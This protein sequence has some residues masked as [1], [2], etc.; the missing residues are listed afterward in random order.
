MIAFYF[1]IRNNTFFDRVT[2]ESKPQSRTSSA[3]TLGFGRSNWFISQVNIEE[4]NKTMMRGGSG[5][6]QGV[7]QVM[8]GV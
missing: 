7:S 2:Q 6:V 3:P 4:C 8:F 5:F 1:V